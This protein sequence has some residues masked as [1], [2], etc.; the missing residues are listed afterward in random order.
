M[1]QSSLLVA[2]ALVSALAAAPVLA[3]TA[4][5]SSNATTPSTATSNTNA[6]NSN[7]S[8]ASP[9]ATTSA[10]NT[11]ASANGSHQFLSQSEWSNDWRLSKIK[12]LNVYNNNNDKLGDIDDVL[13]DKSGQIKA[14][15]IGVGG[16]LG[17]GD[18]Q[19]AVPFEQLKFVM[20]NNRGVGTAG[21]NNNNNNNTNRAA[22]GNATTTGT[23]GAG[24]GAAPSTA[25]SAPS[26]TTP[27]TT[28]G[29]ATVANNTNNN[30]ANAAAN[31]RR[32]D[33]PDRA[34]LNATKDQLK[35]APEFKWNNG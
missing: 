28:P 33:G 8:A 24:L 9:N 2:T 29:G 11:S 13:V 19:V 23:P 21:V 18:H 10:S 7:T 27:A 31:G 16:F 25:T 35:S 12:G 3:Q 22:A 17:I 5:S 4:G 6:A 15:I 34:I 14:V 30:N 32:N 20:D 1:K 26:N